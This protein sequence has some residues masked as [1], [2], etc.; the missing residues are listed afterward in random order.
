MGNNSYPETTYS[1][2]PVQVH[3][4]EQTPSDTAYLEDII[5]IAAGF[6][7]VLAIDD[8]NEV[9]AWGSDAD[10]KLG[11]GG[12]ALTETPVHVHDT[13][14]SGFLSN[15]SKIDAGFEHSLA[16][17]TGGQ[18]WGWGQADHASYS[19]DDRLALS[20]VTAE[21]NTPQCMP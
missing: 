12:P 10:G 15:I 13:G 14:G 11:Y 6:D 3:D 21:Y 7:H 17:D 1:S 19:G 9:W 16:V 8:A 4:G 2:T 5:A 18:V 20:E